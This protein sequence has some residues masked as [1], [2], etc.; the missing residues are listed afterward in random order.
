M[1]QFVRLFHLRS[2]IAA[3]TRRQIGFMSGPGRWDSFLPAAL[4]VFHPECSGPG[5]ARAVTGKG[6]DAVGVRSCFV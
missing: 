5:T 4:I 3:G 2:G 6:P 1:K